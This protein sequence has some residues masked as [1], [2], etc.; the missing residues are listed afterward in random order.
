MRSLILVVVISCVAYVQSRAPLITTEDHAPNK[1][2][3][4]LKN[5]FDVT[6][7]INELQGIAIKNELR[8]NVKHHYNTVLRGFSVTAPLAAIELVRSHS[9]VNYVEEDGYAY[10]DETWGLDRIDQVRLPLDDKFVPEGD[11]SGAHVYVLDTGVRTTHEEF[12]DRAQFVKDFMDDPEGNGTDCRGH[13]THCSG[14]VGGTK[15]G[16][17]KRTNIYGVR[18]L[19]C[20]GRGTWSGIIAAIDWV[21]VNAI[22]PAV[23]S[24]SLGGGGTTSVDAAVNKLYDEGILSLVAAGNNNYDSCRKSP[25]RASKAIT[26]GA[27][28]IRD[29]RASFSNYGGCVDIFAPGRNITAAYNGA[30][31]HYRTISGTSMATPHVAGVCA[32]HLSRDSSLSPAQLTNLILNEASRDQL[33]DIK[34]SPNLLLYI[35]GRV[36]T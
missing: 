3:V 22:R 30:D 21:A 19:G 26:V 35:N 6:K 4:V 28:N 29:I 5:G 10:A 31:D 18:V 33:M 25:A 13:G 34:D 36:R 32:L 16:V 24:M 2:I 11:G 17:A 27:T 20:D 14:T 12:N 23:A 7:V 8:L 9:S 1:F 15:Y